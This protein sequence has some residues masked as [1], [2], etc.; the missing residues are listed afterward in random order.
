MIINDLTLLSALNELEGTIILD[1][2]KERR[3]I[4]V[5]ESISA[6]TD[7]DASIAIGKIRDLD[8]IINDIE[9]AKETAMKIKLDKKDPRQA[10][11]MF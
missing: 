7:R 2:L 6:K 3:E 4:A 8:D 10:S 5:K 1:Y 11:Q 9:T